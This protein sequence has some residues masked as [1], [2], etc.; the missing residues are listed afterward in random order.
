[1]VFDIHLQDMALDNL[2]SINTYSPLVIGIVR[3]T[4]GPLWW[5]YLSSVSHN[6]IS[7]HW[8]KEKETANASNSHGLKEAL[9]SSLEYSFHF[10]P[11]ALIYL[12]LD[13]AVRHRLVSQTVLRWTS[14][15]FFVVRHAVYPYLT[16]LSCVALDV[17]EVGRWHI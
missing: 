11:P 17:Q 9:G 7:I 16:C 5:S 15:Y 12:G 8:K 10:S 1:M 6:V 14:K 3:V 13:N 4:S 2:W